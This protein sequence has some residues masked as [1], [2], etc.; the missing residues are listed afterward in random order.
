MAEVEAPIRANDVGGD[1][2]QRL[3][4]LPRKVL[5]A[6]QE[7]FAVRMLGGYSL[8]VLARLLFTCSILLFVFCS[9]TGA[10]FEDPA[11]ARD[12]PFM[13]T[14]SGW[15]EAKVAHA[16]V[17]APVTTPGRESVHDADEFARQFLRAQ[18]GLTAAQTGQRDIAQRFAHFQGQPS[19]CA[20]VNRQKIPS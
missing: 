6:I 13:I 1:M 11:F 14:S 10:G 15:G 7:D 12:F 19:R 17:L 8:L 16:S 20:V 18:L 3:L 2:G 4:R 5:F 9:R